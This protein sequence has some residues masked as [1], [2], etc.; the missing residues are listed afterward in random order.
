MRRLDAEL[1][2]AEAEEALALA[3]QEDAATLLQGTMMYSTT[4]GSCMIAHMSSVIRVL[5][6]AYAY[7]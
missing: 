4:G 7:L 3:E 2:A 1:Q 6:Q 5:R